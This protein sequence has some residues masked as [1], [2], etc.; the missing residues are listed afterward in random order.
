MV[1]TLALYFALLKKDFTPSEAARISDKVFSKDNC[2]CVCCGAKGTK[3]ILETNSLINNKA[4]FNLY[5]EEN[6]LLI[7]FTKDHIIPKSK[8]GTNSINNLQTLCEICN[9][10]KGDTEI[11]SLDEIREKRKSLETLPKSRQSEAE[12]K[13][14][15][16]KLVIKT[17]LNI[18]I[19]KG[20]GLLALHPKQPSPRNSSLYGLVKKGAE[21]GVLR[22]K[23][24]KI[25][26]KL[27]ESMHFRIAPSLVEIKN[28]KSSGCSE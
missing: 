15:Y 10:V 7:L 20:S 1:T 9:K 22:V 8:G 3:M 5:G 12:Y 16:Q 26:L 11:M 28:E 23:N 27:N 17:D 21:F 6:G 2:T 4:H 18:W 14:K 25:H 13:A 19:T 24:G